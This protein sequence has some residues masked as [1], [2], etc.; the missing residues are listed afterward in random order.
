MAWTAPITW[1]AGQIVS[2]SDLNAQ[3]RDNSL[4][5]FSGR[6]GNLIKRD[7]NASYTTTSATFVDVDATNLKPSYSIASGKALVTF[8]GVLFEGAIASY[9]ASMDFTVDGTRHGSA[10]L[11]G[12]LT[13]NVSNERKPVGWSVIVTG[14]SVAS[15]TFGLQYRRQSGTGTVTLLSGNGTDG[16]DV[17]P[18]FNVAEIG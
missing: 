13:V 5:L 6:P 17:I 7:N 10:G 9:I 2:A 8:S 4:Y 15:H 12:L 11:D 16:Q 1:T 3:I 14:L 18:T